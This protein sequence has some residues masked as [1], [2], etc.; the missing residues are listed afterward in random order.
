MGNIL[1]RPGMVWGPEKEPFTGLMGQDT[2]VI[3][4]MGRDMEREFL[5]MQMGTDM[6]VNSM[7]IYS[8]VKEF[9]TLQ[10]AKNTWVNLNL[11][12]LMER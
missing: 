10:M 1:V 6:R 2:R 5:T 11:G 4:R 3:L 8:T 7:K 12:S 9:I